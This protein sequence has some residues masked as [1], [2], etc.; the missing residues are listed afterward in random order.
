MRLRLPRDCCVDY[1]ISYNT[2]PCTHF[3]GFA[4]MNIF[5]EGNV[6]SK[7][8]FLKRYNSEVGSIFREKMARFPS[9]KC[10]GCNENCTGGCPIYWKRYNPDKEVKGKLHNS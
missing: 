4:L 9:N 7:Y 8:E 5:S 6:V 10:D 2:A 1:R 3:S